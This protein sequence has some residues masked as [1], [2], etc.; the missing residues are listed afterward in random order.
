MAE[1]GFA[2]LVVYRRSAALADE[3]REAVRR[4]DS[5]DVWTSGVQGIRAPDSIGANIAEA[6]GRL[7]NPDQLRLLYIARGSANELEHWFARAEE[8]G[9]PYPADGSARA[10]EIGRMLNGLIRG[11]A[12]S[13]TEAVQ[14][15]ILGTEN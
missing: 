4:W 1:R 3:M 11:L 13:S 10:R 9:L 8:R 12:R 2:Q 14:A 7:S 6:M 15:Q 5:L